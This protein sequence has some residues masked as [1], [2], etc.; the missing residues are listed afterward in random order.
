MTKLKKNMVISTIFGLFFISAV[1]AIIL[2]FPSVDEQAYN[3]TV[4]F[5]DG[6]DWAGSGVIFYK[7]TDLFD[8]T[9]IL[10]L[11]HLKLSE[12]NST[13]RM[14]SERNGRAGETTNL[15][16][17]ILMEGDGLIGADMDADLKQDLML[18]VVYADIGISSPLGRNAE[19]GDSV[20]TCSG[21]L[22]PVATSGVVQITFDDKFRHNARISFG[23]SGSGIFNENGSI[24]GMNSFI[25]GDVI[26]GMFGQPIPNINRERV[27]AIN[28][29]TIIEW[30]K[31]GGYEWTMAQ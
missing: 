12:E 16:F 19:K 8:A 4:L 29:E 28:S 7:Y 24:V 25:K 15:P 31:M 14:Y 6:D 2:S 23:H 27:W 1:S 5:Y 18:V 21:K 9:Y 17:K 20:V 11:K 13:V 22:L 10:T 30:L 3:S 26:P